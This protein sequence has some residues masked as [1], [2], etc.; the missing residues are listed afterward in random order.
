M[1]A[2][3][4]VH[5]RYSVLYM[6]H[7]HEIGLSRSHR[8]YHTH[9]RLRVGCVIARPTAAI[10]VIH[11]MVD[12]VKHMVDTA[13]QQRSRALCVKVYYTTVLLGGVLGL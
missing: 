3:L 5:G 10:Q 6:R 11:V 9:S 7:V 8:F 13:V 2:R 1:V 12:T 4:H